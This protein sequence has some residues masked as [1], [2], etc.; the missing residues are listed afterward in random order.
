[1]TCEEFYIIA[2]PFIIGGALSSIGNALIQYSWYKDYM[3]KRKD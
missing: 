2:L 1:M 3:K